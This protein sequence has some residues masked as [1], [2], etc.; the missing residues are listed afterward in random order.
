MPWH[1][2]WSES[3]FP[4]GGVIDYPAAADRLP[5]LVRGGSIVPMGPTMESIPE[6]HCFNELEL[7]CYPPYPAKV[8]FYDDEG[9]TR[10]Y[11]QGEFS[12]TAVQVTGD[13]ARGRVRAEI[14]AT[15]GGYPDQP[16][17]RT[18]TVRLHRSPPPK[19]MRSSAGATVL[20]FTYEAKSQSVA[21]RLACPLNRATS[22]E[23][24]Y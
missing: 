16:V 6:D 9:T 20:D 10:S 21:V 14:S 22:V 13:Y 11:Q 2:F 19:A 12:T 15:E 23:L 1:D 18:V 8:M 24:D 3:S 17:S 7:Q 5:L 4:G